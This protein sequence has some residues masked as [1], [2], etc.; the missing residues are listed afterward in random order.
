MEYSYHLSCIVPVYNAE[1]Y[2]EK[3]IG[4]LLQIT[5]ISVEIIL[6][7]DG[8]TDS[9]P[10]LLDKYAESNPNIKVIH[11][12]NKGVAVARNTGIDIATGEYI[13]FIDSDDWVV[14]QELTR[15]YNCAQHNNADMIL[16]SA[17]Y[18]NER[19]D[20]IT[21]RKNSEEVTYTVTEQ[22]NI[23]IMTIIFAIPVL[24]IILGIIVWQVRRRKK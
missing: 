13:T 3:C 24:I 20:T 7:D 19:E 18:L 1:Q 23:V 4:S 22:Q 14:P 11:Q 2:L 5:S 17:S 16:N 6:I 8:S 10:I 15:L 9:S 21:I 12:N